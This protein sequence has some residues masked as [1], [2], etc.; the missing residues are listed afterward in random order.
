MQ[1]SCPCSRWA[2]SGHIR[3]S[4]GKP[5]AYSQ[6]TYHTELKSLKSFL[7]I[8]CSCAGPWKLGADFPSKALAQ[9]IC[10]AA[11]RRGELTANEPQGPLAE[12]QGRPMGTCESLHSL[13]KYH[14][15]WQHNIKYNTP[16]QVK[17]TRKKNIVALLMLLLFLFFKEGIK[18]LFF[19]GL[20]K[21]C[22][23]CK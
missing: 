20:I 21:S 12:S 4:G 15:S 6:F 7:F 17:D 18:I 23:P 14:L 5:L 8:V 11:E 10:R 2:T 1:Q 3:L 13:G 22:Q 19:T 9:C 16:Q